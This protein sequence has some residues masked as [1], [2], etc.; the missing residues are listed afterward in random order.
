MTNSSQAYYSTDCNTIVG[1]LEVRK[2]DLAR[3]FDA[4]TPTLDG[5]VLTLLARA[6]S[7]WFRT[8]Q[9]SNVL[10]ASP[11]GIRKVLK[12]LVSQGVVE[13]L[14]AGRMQLY[15]INSEHLAVQP[16]TQLA[17]LFDTLIANI[18]S[19]INTWEYKPK[20]CAMFGSAARGTMSP[21]SDID[22]LFIHEERTPEAP[23]AEQLAGLSTAVTRWT[24]NDASTIDFSSD[25]LQ[26]LVGSQL[27]SDVMREG[28][29]LSGSRSWLQ[30]SLQ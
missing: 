22:L 12:R 26:T 17:N 29:T 14:D 3:P 4:V 16:I 20:Y 10:D 28:L 18:K 11:E 25:E 24:G 30:K 27:I 9:I 8:T 5:G 1:N 13:T 7:A 6:P 2:I 19:E 15:R 23:W 21:S